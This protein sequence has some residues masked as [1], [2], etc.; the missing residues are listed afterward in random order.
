MGVHNVGTVLIDRAPSA[1]LGW[2]T[3]RSESFE[4]GKCLVHGSGEF[5]LAVGPGFDGDRL[6]RQL[7]GR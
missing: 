2:G 4:G 6:W 3:G 5:P 1:L 7:R